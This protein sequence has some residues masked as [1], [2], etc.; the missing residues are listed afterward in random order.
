MED[1][2]E[3]IV[4]EIQDEFDTEEKLYRK[5]NDTCYEFDAKISIDDVNEILA[6]SLPDE[7]DYESLG[8]FVYFVFGEVPEIGDNKQYENLSITILSIDKQRIGWVKIELL[9]EE[10]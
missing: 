9:S 7:E 10:E 4:G 3:E 2:I 5:I 8:G 1:I 6:V